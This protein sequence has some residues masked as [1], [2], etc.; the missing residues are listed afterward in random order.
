VPASAALAKMVNIESKEEITRIRA[1]ILINLLFI[2][3]SP[4]YNLLILAYHTIFSKSS[5]KISIIK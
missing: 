3:G 2:S 1:S 4:F 5:T